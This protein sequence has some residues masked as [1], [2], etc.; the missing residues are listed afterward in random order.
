MTDT[1]AGPIR[2]FVLGDARIETPVGVIEP[3]AEL[4]FATAL[5]LIL[6]RKEPVSRRKLERVLWPDAEEAVASHRLRQTLLKLR[7]AGLPVQG[8]AM[9]LSL[10]RVT[11][12]VDY[13]QLV[14]SAQNPPTDHGS[15]AVL[16]DY[17]PEVSREYSRW[18]ESKRD[19]IT[20]MITPTMLGVISQRRSRGDWAGVEYSASGLLRAA[21]Y[22]EEATL[23]LAEAHAMRGSK[24]E[25]V[26][27]LDRYIG[28]VGKASSDLRIPATALRKR[29]V[30]R[31]PPPSSS[32]ATV[33]MLERGG[34]MQHLGTLLRSAR[35]SRGCACVIRGDAGI[36]KTRLLT[37][38]AAF[39]A[40]QG[41]ASQRV[42]SR[43]SDPMRPLSLFIDLVPMLRTM[44]GAIGCSAETI[45][46]LDRLTRRRAIDES[47]T[48]DH[49]DP[50][51][52]YSNV[53]GALFDLFD[54][55]AEERMMLV[56]VEDIHFL[57]EASR[58]VLIH[59]I[60]WCSSRRV[61]FAFTTREMPGWLF[62]QVPGVV[63]IELRP[64]SDE[65]AS[66]MI[67]SVL[68]SSGREMETDYR[69]WCVRVAD[70][71]PFFLQE[72]AQQWA[73][74]G[75]KHTAPA[76]ISAVL[77]ERISRLGPD[78]LQLLQ[79][80][81]ALENYSTFDRIEAVLKHDP[82]LLLRSFNSLAN[83]GML[84]GEHLHDITQPY[85][86]QP[87]HDLISAAALQRLTR[88]A[89]A[90]LHR[91][92]ATVLQE[93]ISSDDSSAL[94]WDCAKHWQL[95]G[96]S[97]RALR[98]ARSC[99]FHLLGLG[100][101]DA[102]A[103]AF[104]KAISFCSSPI[105]TLDIL[106]AQAQA[107]GQSSSWS[108]LLRIE[109]LTRSLATQLGFP[110]ESSHDDLELAAIRA[111]WKTDHDEEALRRLMICLES[112][113][114]VPD[115]RVKAGTMALMLQDVT[116]RHDEMPKTFAIVEGFANEAGVSKVAA[117]EAEL[118]YHTLCG[119]LATA[120]VAAENLLTIKRSKEDQGDVFRHLLNAS[121][122]Y[123]TAGLFDQS[124]AC[125]NEAVAIA[126]AHRL[127]K[128][129]ARALPML[130]H[131]ALERGLNA[132]AGKWLDEMT[133]L[134]LESDDA[135]VSLDTTSIRVRLAIAR[136]EGTGDLKRLPQITPN[137][138]PRV[139]QPHTYT[140]ALHAAISLARGT[141]LTD[142]ELSRFEQAHLRSRRCIAQAFGTYVLFVAMRRSGKS[143]RAQELVDAYHLTY[144]RETWAASELFAQLRHQLGNPGAAH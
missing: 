51:F 21:P 31:V 19:I 73:E 18:V 52:R 128:C 130:A 116:C 5:Y 110:D 67:R 84:H 74:T 142:A 68:Q 35:E 78:A 137:S 101:P 114:A 64:L 113:R 56:Q 49:G 129:L 94:L 90:F 117:L 72:L 58:S 143:D 85:L 15:L 102:A 27:I 24:L 26:R 104:E 92:V 63:D 4:V 39:A 23:A 111:Q 118:V 41:V 11:V 141:T 48:T 44:R 123:R 97:S 109:R 96:D 71:N 132:E 7:R 62:H 54:A 105:E 9:R 133:R 91:R 131:L 80:C 59:L 28:A 120:V 135:Y 115:H 22:N 20:G 89:R 127:P 38:F 70:G 34:V 32:T 125:L 46:Y 95:A 121:V 108:S 77:E 36:G 65:G 119:S 14:A 6:E 82:H 3:T 17:E 106:R 60:E 124:V 25:S 40:I 10:D 69:D 122:T 1:S 81:A 136:A 86:L 79:V 134:D 138:H 29:I 43:P 87:R 98:L 42:Q 126:Q 139:G 112:D 13:E 140:L 83:S 75:T 37:E 2:L 100:L 16:P 66:T 30:D 61:L 144:R 33:P 45:A 99:G 88:P 76:S 93:Q 50:Q 57:D 53:E 8:S 12:G 47:S 107:Y 55:I 103:D